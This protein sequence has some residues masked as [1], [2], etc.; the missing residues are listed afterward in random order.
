[1]NKQRVNR[2]QAMNEILYLG[3][4]VHKDS[5]VIAYALG[6]G[7]EPKHYGKC[8]SSNL[9]VERALNRICKKFGVDKQDIRIA[10]EAGPSG[11][12]LVR[13]LLQL[14]Y[15]TIVVAPS[16]MERAP[17]EKIKTDRRDALKLAKQLRGQ[18]L[19]GIYIP[20]ARNEA[21]RD[22][23]R[24]RTDASEDLRQHKQRLG[25]FL[26]RQGVNYTGKTKWTQGH[27]NY[28]R[29]TRFADAALNFVLEDYI[30]AVEDTV[31]RIK[32]LKEKLEEV[33]KDWQ[34]KVHVD[35]LKAFRSF[36]TVAAMTIVSEIGDFTRFTHPRQLMAY[37]GLVPSEATSANHRRQG[38]ITKC[39]NSHVRW[40]L[41]EAAQNYRHDPKVSPQ[42]S[43]RQE[44]QPR[45]VKQLSWRAQIRLNY[46]FKRLGARQLRY[47]KVIIAVA[48]ELSAFIW[49]LFTSGIVPQP[50]KQT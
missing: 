34:R 6:S 35:A 4:D 22:L 10:Y 45:A 39:G 44:G 42:L 37:L 29:K 1:M 36:D 47:N 21:V 48:R 20:N 5:V 27:M 26:L 23:C 28:L 40:M 41:A 13:R 11:F 25:A 8:A 43:Q 18:A 7:G 9:A 16:K 31:I 15:D 24:A 46:R 12:I 14:G 3:F 32:A 19:T 50:V 49:E 38:G 33:L 30:Q 2:Q 17:G